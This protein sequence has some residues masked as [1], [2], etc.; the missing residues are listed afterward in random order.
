M[1]PEAILRGVWESINVDGVEGM[2]G[3]ALPKV[4]LRSSLMSGT[5]YKGKAG[6]RRWYGD[7][8]EAFAY[9]HWT[10]DEVHVLSPD[11]ALAVTTGEFKSRSGGVPVRLQTNNLTEIE[12]DLIIAMTVYLDL[13]EALAAGRKLVSLPT[14]T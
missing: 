10:L 9:R 4:E 11:V 3:Y 13:D 5:V 2:L 6:V 12:D 8:T 14:R 7:I 1:G